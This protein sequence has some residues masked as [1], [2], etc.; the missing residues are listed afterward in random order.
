MTKFSDDFTITIGQ[1]EV[2]VK[3][4]DDVVK[5][6]E[7]NPDQHLFGLFISDKLTIYIQKNLHTSLFKDTLLHETLHAI[8]FFSGATAIEAEHYTEE[9]IV[10]ILTPW[11]MLFIRDNPE[12]LELYID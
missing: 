9:I 3:L 5:Y 11:L 4:V 12:V 1:H 10:S 6:S 2:L 8:W 7:Y